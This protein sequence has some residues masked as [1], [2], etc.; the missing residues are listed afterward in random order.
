MSSI[1]RSTSLSVA[2]SA[3]LAILVSACGHSGPLGPPIP[4]GATIL[5]GQTMTSAP[6]PPPGW[7]LRTAVP[8]SQQQ[9]QDTLLRY[10]TKTLQGL[11]PGTTLDATGYGATNTPPCQDV[12]TGTPPVSLT[13]IGDLKPPAGTDPN[14]LVAKTGDIW[15][16]WGWYVFERDDFRKPNRFGYAPDGYSLQIKGKSQ[17][18]Y[19]PSLEGLSPCF[20]CELPDD[21]SPFP[22]VL[23]AD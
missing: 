4:T 14:T 22:M 8:D 1:H 11:P 7:K 2:A 17:P 20:P 10:L 6:P 12:D 21:R 13:T 9:A 5:G 3:F 18:G 16:S 23:K 15:K 19:P